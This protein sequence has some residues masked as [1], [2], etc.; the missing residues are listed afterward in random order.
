MRKYGAKFKEIDI[1]VEKELSKLLMPDT[2]D[3]EA[4]TNVSNNDV[5]LEPEIKNV[6]F[7][8]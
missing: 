7:R 1:D 3:T 6:Y 8:S 5:N 4:N 2:E